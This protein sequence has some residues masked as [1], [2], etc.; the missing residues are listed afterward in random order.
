[1][2]CQ[3]GG[4]VLKVLAMSKRLLQNRT[5]GEVC[6]VVRAAVLQCRCQE[7]RWL[8]SIASNAARQTA[9]QTESLRGGVVVG[10]FRSQSERLLVRVCD[11][12]QAARTLSIWSRT[13]FATGHSQK[14]C[15]VASM[16]VCEGRD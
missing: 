4:R 14:Q 1:M 11:D 7:L 3:A 5:T 8:C 10:A 2:A 12:L 15:S 6:D 13:A 9:A 16:R